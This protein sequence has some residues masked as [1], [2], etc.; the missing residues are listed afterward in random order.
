MQTFIMLIIVILFVYIEV[1]GYRATFERSNVRNRA[2]ICPLSLDCSTDDQITNNKNNINDKTD[3]YENFPI[4]DKV[5][6]HL[7]ASSVTVEMGKTKKY[8]PRNYLELMSLINEM[9]TT[10]P[11][12]QVN[13]QGKNMLKRL[14]PEWLLTQYK[15][16]FSAPFPEFSAL[17]NAYVTHWTTNWLMGNS[18]IYDLEYTDNV[19]K[20]VTRKNQGLLVEK[21]RF[22]EEAGCAKTCLHAC[23]IPTQRFFLEEMGLPV[24]LNPNMTD[25]SCKFEFGVMPMPLE[26]DPICKTPCLQ[27]C[28]LGVNKPSCLGL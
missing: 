15:W 21:C 13:D 1:Q 10:R 8:T 22:L 19:G 18:T 23:K 14:F 12:Q 27:N 9:T 16:M 11:I 6:F 25:Y 5:L 28:S 4:F 17:M 20:T 3:P 2:K 24:T 7:F 26:E